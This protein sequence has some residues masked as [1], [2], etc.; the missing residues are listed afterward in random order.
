M[1]V[2]APATVE[3]VADI[4]VKTGLV[5]YEATTP[6]GAAILAATVNRFESHMEL[7]VLK[8]G[9]GI[10]QRDGEIPN[11]LRVYLAESSARMTEDVE[12]EEAVMLECNLDDMNPERYTHV[13]DLLFGAGAADVFIIPIVMKKSR[14]G[15]MLSVL[16][17]N[18][19]LDK[20]KEIL[21]TETSSIGLREHTLK[22]SIL[23]REIVVVNTKYGDVEVK[24]SYWNGRL[25]NEKPEFE[26]CRKLATEHGVTLEEI[27]KEV[28][29]KL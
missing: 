1:P 26:E 7:V 10:G 16:C 4:P 9:Y 24:R 23:R 13:M 15:H 17:N 12:E 29:K 28:A 22:K 5:D 3:I 6:T 21:F 27:S 11:V 25:V 8:T 14:P 20:M 18:D 19:M 2:P